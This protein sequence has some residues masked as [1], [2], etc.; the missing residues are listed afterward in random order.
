MWFCYF[1]SK[2]VIIDSSMSDPDGISNMFLNK[3]INRT[4][5]AGYSMPLRVVYNGLLQ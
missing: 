1:L 2:D 3:L 5:F 4:I